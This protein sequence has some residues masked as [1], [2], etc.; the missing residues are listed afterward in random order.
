MVLATASIVSNEVC[1]TVVVG[2]VPSSNILIVESCEV[3]VTLVVLSTFPTKNV[4]KV[5]FSVLVSVLVDGVVISTV[6]VST[7]GELVDIGS[8]V[9]SRLVGLV[10]KSVNVIVVD[11][12][13]EVAISLVLLTV[14][15][16]VLVDV[17]LSDISGGV[18]V[19]VCTFVE[20]VSLSLDVVL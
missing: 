4:E 8:V 6:V 19:T 11:S 10:L 16:P 7:I 3:I 17:S 20:A 2:V 14:F 1:V 15:S 12:T 9:V 5:L 18:T 13:V